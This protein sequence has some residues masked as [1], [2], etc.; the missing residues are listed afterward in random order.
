MYKYCIES[1]G[2]SIEFSLSNAKQ[3]AV[4]LILAWS[5]VTLTLGYYLYYF[6]VAV[7]LKAYDHMSFQNVL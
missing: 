4:D 5:L 7:L 6:T 3:R 2:N 1:N